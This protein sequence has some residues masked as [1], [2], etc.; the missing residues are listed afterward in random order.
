MPTAR[1]AHAVGVVDG[2][3]YAVGG[4]INDA[5]TASVD[6]YDPVSDTWSSKAPMPKK[7][8]TH[9]VAVA[10]GTLYA[11]G[12]TGEIGQPEA[13][14]EAYNPASDSWTIEASM[15]TARKWPAAATVNGVIY[16]L[17]GTPA[18]YMEY[19]VNEAFTPGIKVIQF[20]FT[21]QTGVSLNTLITSNTI[22]VSGIN[23]ATAISIT[24]GAYSINDGGFTI[25]AGTVNN[26]NTVSVQQTSSSSYSNHNEYRAYYRR[27]LRHI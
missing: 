3:L 24:G 23:A 5:T 14:V 15:P 8:Y 10:N 17:G 12:G 26:G 2:I 21:D 16:V 4:N 6:A 19:N 22:T 11:I 20:S 18:D 25:A 27:R 1:S 13:T 9:S 7:V